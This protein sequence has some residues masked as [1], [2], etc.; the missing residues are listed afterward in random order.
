[1]GSGKGA[2]TGKG[3]RRGVGMDEGAVAVAG[4]GDGATGARGS[5]SDVR[6]RLGNGLSLL[7]GTTGGGGGGNSGESK[8]DGDEPR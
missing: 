3:T 5:L 8:T 7:R 6:L 4:T 2:A 1:M